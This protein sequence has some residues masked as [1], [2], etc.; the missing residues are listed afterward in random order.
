[1]RADEAAAT[2]NDLSVP[3]YVENYSCSWYKVAS[4][5]STTSLKSLDDEV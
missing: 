5:N 1:M 2:V 3:Y 4:E